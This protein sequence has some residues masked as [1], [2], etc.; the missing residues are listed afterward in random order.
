MKAFKWLISSVALLVINKLRSEWK[1]IDTVIANQDTLGPCDRDIGTALP[2]KHFLLRVAQ[3][4]C[5][6]T[7]PLGERSW[8]LQH[9]GEMEEQRTLVISLRRR[10]VYHTIAEVLKN[11]SA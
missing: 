3:R 2:G 10:D 9:T 1:V 5:Y 6:S 8:K 11:A 4:P 7:R